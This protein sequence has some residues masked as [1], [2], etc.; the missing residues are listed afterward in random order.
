M[1]EM[2]KVNLKLI[3]CEQQPEITFYDGISLTQYQNLAQRWNGILSI[4]HREISTYVNDDRACYEEIDDFPSRC[5]LTGNYYINDVAYIA[6]V[7]PTGFQIMIQTHLT[8]L[9]FGREDDYLGLE[10]TLYTKSLTDNFVVW[11]VDS[12]VI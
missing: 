12:S 3:E 6:R 9:E 4:V 2:F 7:N 10:V 5:I 1:G 8:G 11:G